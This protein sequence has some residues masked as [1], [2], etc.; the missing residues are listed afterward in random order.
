MNTIQIHNALTKHVKYFQG[1]Y[2]LDILPSTHIKPAIIIINFDKHYMPGSQ[3]V[4]VCFS[5]SG[6]AEYFDSYGL[7]PF[8][9]G[10]HGISAAPLN[11]LDI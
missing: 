9:L 2:P 4:A 3:W 5:V 6:Y 11:F 10:N 1:V 8:K 7:P